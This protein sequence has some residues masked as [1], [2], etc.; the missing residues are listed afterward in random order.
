MGVH[1]GAGVCRPAMSTTST[2]RSSKA[3]NRRTSTPAI[4]RQHLLV[5]DVDVDV[6]AGVVV[7]VVI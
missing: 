2:R 5:V 7:V 3:F 1:A 6:V 4:Q